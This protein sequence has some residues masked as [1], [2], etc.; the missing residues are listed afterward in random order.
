MSFVEVDMKLSSKQKMQNQ[1]LSYCSFSFIAT[2]I[3]LILISILGCIFIWQTWETID[4]YKNRKSSVQ[5]RKPNT[6]IEITF[7]L[8]YEHNHV[9]QQ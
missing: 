7:C 2:G 9:N 8:D 1:P 4:K 6:V 3:K 5:V